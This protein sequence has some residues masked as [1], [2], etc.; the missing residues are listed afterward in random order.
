MRFS[1]HRDLVEAYVAAA[2]TARSSLAPG[3]LDHLRSFLADD[4]TIRM[5]SAWTDSPRR[6][7]ST[8][9]DELVARLQAPINQAV[10]LTTENL[11][12]VEADGE[13]FVEHLSTVRR[14]GRDHVSMV[15]HIFTV[16]DD[17]ITGIRAYRNDLGSPAGGAARDVEVPSCVPHVVL[18]LPTP[19]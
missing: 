3:D 2:Q 18:R 10:S 4:V 9:A 7:V 17:R 6:T 11:N 15:C 12:V 16:V 1:S 8:S 19:W 14:D 13:V 5:A